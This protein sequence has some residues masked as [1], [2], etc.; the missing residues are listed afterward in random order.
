MGD[1]A[2]KS[3]PPA[4]MAALVDRSASSAMPHGD[5]RGKKKRATCENKQ[6]ATSANPP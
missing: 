5:K 2:R 1:E 4:E 6:I 3:S